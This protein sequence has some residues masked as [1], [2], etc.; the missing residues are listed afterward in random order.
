M[1]L[2]S[3]AGT[4]GA[5]PQLPATSLGGAAQLPGVQGAVPPAMPPQPAPPV[6]QVGEQPDTGEDYREEIESHNLAEKMKDEE[7]AMIGSRCKDGYISDKASRKDW[8]Q[9]I[10]EWLKVATQIR[11]PKTFPWPNASNI[12]FP[13]M[14]I[15]AMQFSARAYPSLVPANGQVVSAKTYGKDPDGLKAARAG[16]V[17]TYMSWQVT[18]DMDGWEEDMDRLLM[19]IAVTGNMYK[20]TF[21]DKATDK[22]CSRLVSAENLIV[23]YWTRNLRDAERVSERIFL[24]PREVDNRILSGFYCDVDLGDPVGPEGDHEGTEDQDDKKVVPFEII[25]QHTYADLDDDGYEEPVIITFELATAKVLRIVLRADMED[26]KKDGSQITHIG[27]LQYYTK[28]GFIPNP[29]G[30]FY[31]L[32]FGHLLGPLNESVNSVI[33]QLVDAGTVNNLQAGFMGKGLRVKGGNYDFEP[34]EWKWVNATGDDLR[35]QIVP[36]PTKEPSPVLMNLL[37]YLVGAGKELASIAEI[38]VGKMPGQNTPATTTQS[39]I[40]QGMKVFT[41]IYKRVYRSLNEEFKKLY[42]LNR[43]YLDPNTVVKVLDEPIGP[44]DFDSEDYDICP[45]AD[46]SASSISEKMQ[47]AQ[48]L[49]QLLPLGTL[50]P[51]QV[52]MRILEAQ[53]QPNW[54]KLIPGMAQTGQP[55]PPPPDPK[56]LEMQMKQEAEQKKGDLQKQQAEHKMHI[57]GM[58]AEQQLRNKDA[59]ARINLQ[60]K[61]EE[62][63]LQKEADYHKQAIF[64]RQSQQDLAKKA[65]ETNQKVTH[66]QQTHQQKMQHA[67]EQNKSKLASQRATSK[68]GKST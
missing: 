25:E 29:N 7:L 50:D 34:G 30:S 23:N 36:L 60:A 46:P 33:N 8:E 49:L 16:R 61:R 21:Y 63:N 6:P 53:E 38:F 14:G 15:A 37:Q 20:K 2:N 65:V 1:N 52:T 64:M 17:S 18:E 58:T 10:E 31:D 44:G 22:I 43:T 19:Q 54:Q 3:P 45:S 40:E 59:E 24:Y 62:L 12:K 39:S 67:E 32:G 28:F 9:D 56:I 41:A 13:L 55:A 51:A 26:V 27:S 11:E 42:K 5:A 47:K 35:K 57:D 68:T 48:A 4:Q 66:T